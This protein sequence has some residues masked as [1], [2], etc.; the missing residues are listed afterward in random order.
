MQHPT[1]AADVARLVVEGPLCVYT[2]QEN[3][4]QWLEALAG[5]DAL[6]LDLSRVEECDSAG[7]QL[8]LLAKR[9][10]RRLGKAFA[11]TACS[12]AV[13]DVLAFCNLQAE[14]GLA[15]STGVRS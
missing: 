4:R 12:E 5:A 1:P 3:K 8:L 14:F 2:A 15:P 13:D 10:S 6:A 11:V 7:L 9:E